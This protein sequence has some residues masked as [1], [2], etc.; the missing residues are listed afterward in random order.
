M[1]QAAAARSR[2]RSE[3]GDGPVRLGGRRIPRVASACATCARARSTADCAAATVASATARA[4]ASRSAGAAGPITATTVSSA[5]TWS[6]ACRPIRCSLPAD[7]GRDG[8]DL[9]DA[10]LALFLDRDLE[11]AGRDFGQFDLD[12]AGAGRPRPAR[13]ITAGRQ[14]IGIRRRMGSLPSFSGL[15]SCRGC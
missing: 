14:A 10:R 8:E 3:K 6:P 1:S 15:R 4:R 5:T 13:P 7:G 9:A 12:R 11:G 2:A